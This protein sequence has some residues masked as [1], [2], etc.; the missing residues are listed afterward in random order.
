MRKSLRL[1]VALAVLIALCGGA[2]ML[3]QQQIGMWVFKRGVE[4]GVG[5]DHLAGLPDGL[6]V[7]LC[8]TGSPLPDPS[9]A[10]PCSVVIAGRSPVTCS[11]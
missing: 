6:H 4:R 9:R 1:L 3:F 7:A 2:A 8:G 11:M 5:R 10:G